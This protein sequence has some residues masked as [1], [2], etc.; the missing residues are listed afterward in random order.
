MHIVFD[1]SAVTRGLNAM[2]PTFNLL[3]G[4]RLLEECES[5]AVRELPTL[6]LLH[7]CTPPKKE[8]LITG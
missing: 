2:E 1:G 5:V 4:I 3:S 8:C 6:S 7:F